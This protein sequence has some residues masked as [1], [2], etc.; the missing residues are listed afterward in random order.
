M[1]NRSCRGVNDVNGARA[2]RREWLGLAVIA[3]PCLLYSMDLTVLN[4][5]VP[6][7]SADLQPSSVQLLWIV[8]IYGFMLAGSLITM[9]TI[10]DRIGRRKLLLI[11]AAA[12][13]GASVLTAFSTSAEQLIVARGLLGVAAATLAPSTLSLI[14]NM[15]MD[16]RQ[17]TTAI[18]I[19]VASFSAGAAIGPVVGGALLEHFWWGSVFL[20][21]VPVMVLLLILGPAL[22][23]EFRN[24]EAGRLDP[25]SAALSIVAVLA[26]IYGLK[27]IA[28]D[29]VG[30]WSV[31]AILGGIG[32]A[33]VFVRRQLAL[34]DPLIDLGLFREGVFAAALAVNV[35]DFFIGFGI[36]LFIAQYLQSVLGLSPLSA[37]FWT[38]PLAAGN[39]VGSMLT[40]VFVR[41]VRPAFVMAGGLVLAAIGFAVVTQ[42]HGASGLPIVVTGSVLF[43]VGLAPLTTVSTD[44]VVGVAPPERAGSASSILETSSELGG[45]L[46]I[47]VLG[48]IGTAMYRGQVAAAMPVAVPGTAAH[49][50]LSTLAG[51]ATVAAQLP[52]PL[53]LEVLRVSR[54]AFTHA[55]ALVSAVS[56]TV[57]LAT[58]IVAAVLLRH[59]DLR[60]ASESIP[61]RAQ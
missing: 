21:A 9:G 20:V 56:A 31:L 11:G 45:A 5:A 38:V 54:D 41:R 34:T 42:I 53:R 55:F 14:R 27:Q 47:A 57:A 33:W 60:D 36:F 37:G 26:V 40:P 44:I 15:F 46:G 48:S 18:A 17:R 39:I 58:A 19:W 35:L 59:V 32:V 23:P 12:F 2:T 30:R 3:L 13:G 6:R 50:A 1:T 22:L 7:L 10:G 16:V 49:A 24:P 51:A 8:D 25:M 29:G 61:G 52:D 28:Q 4:L 43:S